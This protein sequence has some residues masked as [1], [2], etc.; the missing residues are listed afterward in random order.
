MTLTG[1]DQTIQIKIINFFIH[2]LK[3]TLVLILYIRKLIVKFKD[4][5]KI[6]KFYDWILD[7]T[8]DKSNKVLQLTKFIVLIF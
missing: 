1:T 2:T 7:L 8:I 3:I 6:F 4:P 5:Y